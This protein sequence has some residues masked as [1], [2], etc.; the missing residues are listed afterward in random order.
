VA[1]VT[2]TTNAVNAQG[3]AFV[4][5]LHEALDRLQRDYANSAVV[6]TGTGTW[7]R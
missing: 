6:L 5:D 1:V 2:M 7:R 3:S 4:A